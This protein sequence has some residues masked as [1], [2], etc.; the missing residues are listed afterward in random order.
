MTP[1]APTDTIRYTVRMPRPH[2]H[3]FA[4]E[5]RFPASGGDL[6][7]ALPV[8]NPGSYLVREF[9]KHVQSVT[10]ETPDGSPLQVSRADKSSFLVRSGGAEVLLRYEVY[11]NELSVRTSHLDGSH[12]FWNGA[13]LF[14]YD[15][16]RRHL[17]HRVRVEA[18]AAWRV[19]TA[20]DPDPATGE[21]VAADYDHLVDSPFECGPHTVHRFEVLGVP[22]ELLFWGGEPPDLPRVLSEVQRVCEHEALF[23]GGLPHRRYLFIVHLLEKGRSGLEHRD[24]SVLVYARNGWSTPRGREDFLHLVAHEYFHLWNMKRLR[25]AGLT[26]LDYG[27]ENYTRL[28]WAFEGL[29]SYYDMLLTRR[30]GLTPPGRYLQR[31][32]EA[33]TQLHGVPGRRVMT[34]EDASLQAWVKQYRPDEN[35]ANSAVSYY[36]K[37]ELVGFLLDITLRKLTGDEKSLD[38]V[39]RLLWARYG[40]QGGGVPEDAWEAAAEEVAGQSLRAF[41]DRALRSTEELDSSSLAHVGLDL[42]FRPKESAGDKGGT[43]PRSRDPRPRGWLGANVR[44]SGTVSVVYADS[45]A[46]DAGL[47][48]DDEVIALDGAR[49]DGAALLSRI[50]ERAPGDTVRLT[51]FRRD[52]LMELDVTLGAKPEDAVWLVRSDAPTEAQKRAYAAWIGAAW[53]AE[54]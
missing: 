13:T 20:L 23:F 3:R 7:V 11:A 30:A 28:L 54:G 50:D 8:W 33:F 37:G 42:R 36:L 32:G 25:P 9:A 39:M 53:D 22:H 24:S 4:V 29:T 27:R 2:T 49:V 41:F 26:P 21:Y 6:L 46:M 16:A 15:E 51:F 31:L 18:P 52:K 43:P 12:A 5:A 35:S 1:P 44:Q 48:V 40:V 34:L 47:Y 19:S 14:L 45:P 10:A 17:E 38:D